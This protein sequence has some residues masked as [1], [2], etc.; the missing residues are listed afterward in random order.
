[1]PQYQ[2]GYYQ[3]GPPQQGYYQQQPQVVYVQQPQQRRDDGCCDGCCKSCCQVLCCLCCLEM[4]C[5]DCCGPDGPGGPGVGLELQMRRSPVR[6]WGVGERQV[7]NSEYQFVKNYKCQLINTTLFNKYVENNGHYNVNIDLTI[8]AVAG[9][10]TSFDIENAKTTY[11]W[12]QEKSDHLKLLTEAPIENKFSANDNDK[13]LGEKIA[14]NIYNLCRDAEHLIIC[15]DCD[16]EGEY[17][18]WEVFM[19]A[20]FGCNFKKILDCSVLNKPIGGSTKFNRGNTWRMKFSHLERNHMIDAV[21]YPGKLNENIINAVRCRSEIDLRSGTS[22]TRL[23]TNYYRN[24]SNIV[25]NDSNRKGSFV[26]SYGPCQFP[27]LGF[28]VDRYDRIQAF[29]AEMYWSIFI[30]LDIFSTKLKWNRNRLFDRYVVA[31]IYENLFQKESEYVRIENLDSKSVLKFKPYP[32]TTVDLQKDCSKYFKI[33]AKRSLNAAEYLYQQSF[34]SYPRTETNKFATNFDF[35]KILDQLQENGKFKS[36]SRT[37]LQPGSNNFSIPRSGQRDDGAH[38]PIHPII[39]MSDDKFNS[40][41]HDQKQVYEYIVRR[42]LASCSKDAVGEQTSLTVRW[43]V[44]QNDPMSLKNGELFHVSFLKVSH[45][46]WLEY[47]PFCNWGATSR[48]VQDEIEASKELLSRMRV[49]DFLKMKETGMTEGKTAPPKP[50]T[51]TELIT[52]MDKNGIGTDAT[53]ADHIEKIKT[54]KYVVKDNKE[55]LVPTN[56]GISLVHG[57][58]DIGL[59]DSITKPFFRGD[60]ESYLV[61]ICDGKAHREVITHQVIQRYVKYYRKT[62]DNLTKL[63]A[64]YSRS[65]S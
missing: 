44:N 25:E 39:S 7:F 48:K 34:I 58:Q 11:K 62:S 38:P 22:F 3:Q 33:S 5:G 28:V 4:L 46:N 27:T 15:T 6:S 35:K 51:E 45:K 63:G 1:M 16:R 21:R 64:A 56:L 54:R 49:G 40:L 9:H 23:L 36:I 60:F 19:S 8:T 57:F 61:D 59:D 52:L 31:Q 41:T 55:C 26:V 17:I 47:M 50:L 13:H 32:L 29:S 42:F 2:Q 14:K 10:V 30:Q 12:S 24:V 37:K 53:I 43:G 18:G 20:N 65:R